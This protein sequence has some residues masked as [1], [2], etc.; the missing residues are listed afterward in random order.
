ML[1]AV[2]ARP[3]AFPHLEAP[4]MTWH[5]KAFLIK[6][7]LRS[8]AFESDMSSRSRRQSFLVV[9]SS[10]LQRGLFRTSLVQPSNEKTG[11]SSTFSSKRGAGGK[12]SAGTAIKMLLSIGFHAMPRMSDGN[13]KFS[14]SRPLVE[15]VLR[16]KTI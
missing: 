7:Q 15:P 2:L 11:N 5:Q 6:K 1:F 4:A 14:S 8:V 16:R 13:S 9:K 3:N 10:R 12:L